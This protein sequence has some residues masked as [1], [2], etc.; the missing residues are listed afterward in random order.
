[1][2]YTFR[3]KQFVTF[4]PLI[5]VFILLFFLS[6]DK[7]YASS[8]PSSDFDITISTN[9]T[10]NMANYADRYIDCSGQN[11]T[12]TNNATL[13][14][15][16]AIVDN[17]DFTDDY[18]LD[19]RI[20]NLTIDAGSSISANGRGYSGG[21]TNNPADGP[22]AGISTCSGAAFGGGGSHGGRG[23][24][25]SVS[26]SNANDDFLGP[27]LLGS[28]AGGGESYGCTTGGA[29]GGA[30]KIV[31]TG[32]INNNGLITANG[33]AG[34]NRGGGGAGGAIWIETGRLLGVG[35]ITANGGVSTGGD[36]GGG[37]VLI[38][39]SIENTLSGTISANS[40]GGYSGEN[41][42]L[43]FLNTT[44]N[45][46]LIKNSQT[47]W[48]D[49]TIDGSLHNF[50][51][52]TIQNNSTLYINGYYTNNS[53][54]TGHNFNVNNFTLETGSSIN[55]N[56][57]GFSGGSTNDPAD[58]PGA[59]GSYCLSTT[60][61]TGAG[62]GHGSRGGSGVVG[63]SSPNGNYLNP[64]NLGS[65]GGGGE[66]YGCQKGGNGGG[67]L[68]VL[69]AGT[70]TV[71]GSISMNGAGASNNSGGGA[72]G[73]V[74]LEGVD[75]IGAGTISA[76]GGDG[77]GGDGSGGRIAI[78][79]SSSINY[80]GTVNATS[81]GGYGGEPGT[82]IF[83]NTS[84]NDLTIK[85]SQI[86]WMNPTLESSEQ[87]FNNVSVSPS[88]NWRFR[89]YYT[90]NN[91]GVGVV[92][93]VNNFT[94][95][96]GTVLTSAGEGFRGKSGSTPGDGPGG[97]T[98]S[99]NPGYKG[100]GASYGG[101]GGNGSGG[102]TSP[103]TYGTN[104]ANAPYYLG[105]GGG[106]GENYGC[107]AGGNGGGAIAIVASG[108]I[109]HDGTINV[110]GSAG[111]YDVGGGGSGG[112][113]LLS[114]MN[115][116]GSG[117]IYARGGSSTLG[118]GGGGGRVAIQYSI[119]NSLSAPTVTGG[120][121]ASSGQ[122]GT[123]IPVVMPY[124]TSNSLSQQTTNGFFS[125]STGTFSFNVG[126][127]QTGVVLTPEVRV[128]LIGQN[129]SD[130][131]VSG[132]EITMDSSPKLATV[133]YPNLQDQSSYR[134]EARVCDVSSNCSAWV[135]F[136]TSDINEID[137]QTQFNQ[138]PSVIAI[139]NGET[140][141]AGLS[142]SINSTYTDTDGAADLDKLY[143]ILQ[144]PVGTD[145]EYYADEGAD[146]AGQI[147][148]SVAGSE[149]VKSITYD[150]DAESPDANSITKTWN[151]TLDWNWTETNNLE[152]GVKSIDDLGAD[153]GYSYTDGNYI[154]END[155]EFTGSLLVTS[156]NLGVLQDGGR[157]GLEDTLTWTGVKVVYQ[158]T[159][160]V[161][162]NDDDFNVQLMDDDGDMW[163]DLLSSGEDI[164]ITSLPD[165]QTDTEDIHTLSIIDI[166]AGGSA[167]GEINYTVNIDGESP[168]EVTSL[169]LEVVS[170]SSLKL[171]WTNPV[172]SDLLKVSLVRKT[173]SAPDNVADGDKVYEGTGTSYTDSGLKD[174]TKYYYAIFTEDDR[175]NI[176]QGVSI[177][178]TTKKIVVETPIVPTE[179][180]SPT[181][182]T[183]P[184]VNV[185]ESTQDS[186][187]HEESI[188]DAVEQD[189]SFN[190]DEE[191]KHDKDRDEG[192]NDK[193]S[194]Q[195]ENTE[196]N[197]E[198]TTSPRT[199]LITATVSVLVIG[200]VLRFFILG[201]RQEY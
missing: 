138:G 37:K 66:N 164:L 137:F 92:F 94:I 100:P 127:T 108:D 3:I 116:G 58:G 152:Y 192:K 122:A 18:G 86:W 12:V 65:G 134:W 195:G 162:P 112:S 160:D 51:N 181:S 84:T 161:Y 26:Y 173:A 193:G 188:D 109:I 197:K 190:K 123:Y 39:Y 31:A 54:G 150:R 67:A 46:L 99:C 36:G 126:H 40:P 149:Y 142:I 75:I 69:A 15:V 11:L 49:P 155:L 121:G 63:Y 27:I 93:R 22:G 8:C 111:F 178:G 68:K 20:N 129:F 2:L 72:G 113:V 81:P 124:L 146:A 50:N 200:G 60:D 14:I 59:G 189:E 104:E 194:N 144:N 174:N 85:N 198:S 148:V 90:N 184:T 183:S 44:T 105:S 185:G 107:R 70:I 95:G 128:A 165:S 80:I 47:W 9:T 97:S 52:V 132:L 153:S 125:Q 76:N 166:P 71:D 182:P 120:A 169:A 38:K 135:P 45:D 176:S 17:A 7:V 10:W 23:G 119:S 33:V 61:R 191:K 118:G 102:L 106:G 177:N 4:L 82:V 103:A 48:A 151:I 156:T 57:R 41:G 115:V 141:Y 91:D 199:Y 19:L 83:L 78:K 143:L 5:F 133:N 158:G 187:K 145:I 29:G 96:T 79:Y 43:V 167:V 179:T 73:S 6:T 74:L 170:T 139:T 77:V 131:V 32:D 110:D 157:I 42:T 136:S 154:Y 140:M 1:M 117:S 201:S 21:S 196:E 88:I 163:L 114:G 25:G 168:S 159:T 172:D 98:G 171:T 147:P 87:V 16:S 180:E 24:T 62:G 186:V 89:A 53:D 34:A 64:V 13:T 130:P 35:S 55:G 175:G 28:G 101:K 30:I 56:G